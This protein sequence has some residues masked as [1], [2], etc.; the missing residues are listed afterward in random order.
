MATKTTKAAAKKTTAKTSAETKKT[1]AKKSVASK[2]TTVKTSSGTK[3]PSAKNTSS[4][5]APAKKTQTKTTA[6]KTAVKKN[7]VAKQAAVEQKPASQKTD[8]SD[9][10]FVVK[11]HEA[12]PLADS[13]AEKIRILTADTKNFLLN[14]QRNE[15]T[16]SIIY[17]KVAAFVKDEKNKN[18]LLQISGEEKKHAGIWEKI[19]GVKVQPHKG[20]I[21]WYTLLAKILGYTFTL[22]LMENGETNAGPAYEKIS[23]EVPEAKQI[24]ADENKHESELLGMLDEER[25]QYVGSMVL[26]LSDA[27]VELTGTLAGLTFAMGNLRLVA[28]SGLITGIA[29]TLSMTSSSY[30]SEKADN[31]PHALKSSLYTGGVY[32][33][34]VVLLILPYLLLPKDASIAAVAILA[35]IVIIL[36]AAFMFYISVA[37][38]ESFWKKFGEMAIISISVAVLSFVIGLLVKHFLGIEI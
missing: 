8:Y 29:A 16:E 36:I 30:L 33:L 23:S 9:K 12:K 11:E 21:F 15:E 4:K 24:A 22:K 2:S 34:T 27:L 38:S 17:K 5:N 28:L 20:K 18:I 31:N 1:A 13:G 19:T 32:M 3:K 37:K 25:L 14:A 10:T 6:K 35:A 7:V 26:G